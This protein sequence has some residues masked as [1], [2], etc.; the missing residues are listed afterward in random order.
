MIALIGPEVRHGVVS[1]EYMKPENDSGGWVRLYRSVFFHEFADEP[2]DR[3]T[4]WMYLVSLA[5]YKPHDVVFRRHTYH[6]ERGQTAIVMSDL[7]TKAQWSRQK[8]KR[9]FALLVKKGMIQVKS[10]SICCV[11][12]ILNYE[13][14]QA[15]G[16]G[17]TVPA[18]VPASVPAIVPANASRILTVEGVPVPAIVPASVPPVVPQTKNALRKVQETK[19]PPT[20]HKVTFDK[21]TNQFVGLTDDLKRQLKDTYPGVDLA[22]VIR[23]AL[24]WAAD[25]R[26]SDYWRSLRAFCEH[27]HTYPVQQRGLTDV[28]AWDDVKGW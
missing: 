4:A 14:Y 23:E 20:P 15:E 1:N 17:T 2:W 7:A 25:N 26:R 10:D 18:V 5:A 12:A 16:G 19:N 6:L 28:H 21:Q 8:V 27:S 9:F 11:V 3:I 22:Q 24:L 13:K